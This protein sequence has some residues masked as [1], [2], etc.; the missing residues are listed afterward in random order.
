MTDLLTFFIIL[1]AGLVFS[2][3][4]KRLHLPYVTALIIAGVIVGP[5]GFD[6]VQITPTMASGIVRNII[7]GAM[8][9]SKRDAITIYTMKAAPMNA[10]TSH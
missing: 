6:V 10:T 9:D 2:D 3:V 8:N 4:F 1:V 7:K 5:F